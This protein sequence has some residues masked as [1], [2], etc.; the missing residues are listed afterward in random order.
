MTVPISVFPVPGG[1]KRRIPFGGPLKPVNKSLNF[2]QRKGEKRLLSITVI[3]YHV[4]TGA[5]LA[6][7]LFP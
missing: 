2:K 3:K 7:R 5:A 6:I 1:P 4:L